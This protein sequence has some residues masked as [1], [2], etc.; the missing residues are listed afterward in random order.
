MGSPV[1]GMLWQSSPHPGAMDVGITIRAGIPLGAAMGGGHQVFLSNPGIRL[2]TT[3]MV[4][5]A[6]RGPHH[7]AT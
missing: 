3:I 4:G 6:K 7:D 5:A 2:R 1:E